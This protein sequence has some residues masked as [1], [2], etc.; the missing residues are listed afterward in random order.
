MTNDRITFVMHETTGRPLCVLL[1]A[2]Y[3]GDHGRLGTFFDSRH[4]LNAPPREGALMTCTGT[5]EQ[6]RRYARGLARKGGTP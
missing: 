5:A 3:G 6:W 2:V 1:Q 4:W